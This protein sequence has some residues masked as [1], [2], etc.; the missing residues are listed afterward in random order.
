MELGPDQF[1][2][3]IVVQAGAKLAGSIRVP[4]VDGDLRFRR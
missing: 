2:P 3:T 4:V 1:Q